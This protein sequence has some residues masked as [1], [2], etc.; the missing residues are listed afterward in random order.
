MILESASNQITDMFEKLHDRFSV[1]KNKTKY[2]YINMNL[3]N[4]MIIQ[5]YIKCSA[6]RPHR[7]YT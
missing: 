5:H 7:M 2:K 3:L 6:N 1:N 4:D